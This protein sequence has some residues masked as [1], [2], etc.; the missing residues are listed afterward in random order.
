MSK[1]MG[2][3]LLMP[4]WRVLQLLNIDSSLG[5]YIGLPE[6]LL[7]VGQGG[8]RLPHAQVRL[9]H[10]LPFLPH[11]LREPRLEPKRYGDKIKCII[12]S[13]ATI[14][15]SGA[16]HQSSELNNF[17]FTASFSNYLELTCDP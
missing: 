7:W 11:C 6:V 14:C 8:L 17:Y 4:T 10:R 9:L 12:V 5:C 15:F 16:R 1:F 2:S 3:L 13:L